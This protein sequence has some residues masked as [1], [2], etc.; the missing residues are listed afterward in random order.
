MQDFLTAAQAA[1]LLGVSPQT[2]AVWRIT[3]QYGLPFIK[4]G[5]RVKYARDAVERWLAA[6][7][8]TGGK[9]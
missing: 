4:V 5:G 8:N 2:L 1:M 9:K 6:R 7:T 3:G